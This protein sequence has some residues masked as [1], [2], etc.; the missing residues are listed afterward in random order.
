M[1]KA[2]E[3]GLLHPASRG[4][5]WR[6]GREESKEEDRKKSEKAAAN[7]G[8]GGEGR[9]GEGGEK[10]VEGALLTLSEMLTHSHAGLSGLFPFLLPAQRTTTY[11]V[12]SPPPSLGWLQEY[13]MLVVTEIPWTA[14]ILTTR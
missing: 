14:L 1:R 4:V 5:G 8:E 9:G 12:C 7:R 13:T 10:R 11:P 3:R 2:H 6:E